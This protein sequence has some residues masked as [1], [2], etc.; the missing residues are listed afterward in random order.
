MSDQNALAGSFP[1]KR[2]P[3]F[4]D[5]QTWKVQRFF[6][7]PKHLWNKGNPNCIKNIH[8]LKGNTLK[9]DNYCLLLQATLSSLVFWF[10][11]MVTQCD[12]QNLGFGGWQAWAS[13]LCPLCK[14]RLPSL[15][16]FL[17]MKKRNDDKAEIWTHQCEVL[18]IN[19]NYMTMDSIGVLTLSLSLSILIII[20][21]IASSL[22]P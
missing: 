8:F 22:F 15:K 17:H 14:E 21:N 16:L 12:G 5:Y 1:A 3:R 10:A 7:F 6:F 11:N 9:V 20:L 13:P 4:I 2:L 18:A 19:R